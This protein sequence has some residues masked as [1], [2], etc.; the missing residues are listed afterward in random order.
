MPE[1]SPDGPRPTIAE[2][3]AVDSRPVPAVL[4]DRGEANVAQT[5]IPKERYISEEFAKQEFE[6][7]WNK[8]WQMACRLEDIPEKGDYIVYEIGDQSLLVVRTGPDEVKAH[9]NVCLHRGRTLRDEDGQAND[10]RCPFH[11]FAWNIDGSCKFIPNAWDFE[12]IDKQAFSLPEARVSIWEGFVFVNLDDNAEDLESFLDIVPDAYRTRGW[13]LGERTKTVHIQKINRCN[14]KVALEA[15]IE[16]FHV[17]T[18]HSSAATYLGDANTQYDVWDNSKHTRMISPR[19]LHSPNIK[20][21]SDVDV[22]RAALR[23]TLGDAA[24]DLELPEGSSGP[25]A[26]I[27]AVRRNALV[28]QGVEIAEQATDSELIDT[29]HYH[30]FPNLVCWAGW[31]SYLV[32]RFRPYEKDPDMS[33]MDIMFLDPTAKPGERLEPQVIGPDDSHHDA[34]QLGGFSAVFDEDSGNLASL[35]RGLKAMTTKGPVTA[36]YQEA[37]I[38]H[39]HEVLGKYISNE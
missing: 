10:F 31:G 33:V 23:T 27:G 34:P 37:R 21:I 18:T 17:T 8:V 35:Q 20:S 12:H 38:R 14:W 29:I 11:G 39:F 9:Y 36:N 30:I 1:R 5:P 13:S 19:G 6:G 15:F 7:L 16:S 24:D 32:Y 28:E 2:I 22:F 25:R 4:L 3:L 26:A